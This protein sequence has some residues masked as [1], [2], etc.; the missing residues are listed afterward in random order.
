MAEESGQGLGN[1]ASA[2]M[3]TL[4]GAGVDH[5]FANPGT[6]EMHLVQA[7][8][9][10]TRIHPVLTLFEGVASGAADGFGRMAGR[11]AATLLHL[12]AGLGHATA[13]LH[14]ARR[15]GTPL[16]NL[17][18]DHAR[19]HRPFDA[20]LD[21]DI[22]GIARPFSSWVRTAR[23]AHGL[24]QDGAEA[25][26]AAS[27][28]HPGSLG[29]IATLAIPVDC[30][31]GAAPGPRAPVAIPARAQV[32]EAA[33]AAAASA[34]RSGTLLLLDGD[35]LTA[36]GQR[37]AAALAQKTGA[38]VSATT[39]PARVEQGPQLPALARLPYFPEDV[40]RALAGVH[41][42]LRVG[43]EAPVSFFAYEGVPSD[44][45]PEGAQVLTLAERHEDVLD[46]LA[47][48]GAAL[49]VTLADALAQGQRRPEV[50]TG[51]LGAR[52]VGATLAAMLP[53][54]AIVT[55]DSG[56]GGAAAVPCASAAPHS[57]LNLTGG[58]IGMG[59]P[60]ATGAA[61]AC[62]GRPVFALLGDGGALYSLQALWTQ[63]RESLPVITLIYNNR[64]YNILDHEYRRL[65]IN[66]VGPR[67]ESLFDLSRPD[68][69]FLALAK[70]FGVP[71]VR[72]SEGPALAEAIGRAL[73]AGGP[74][75]IEVML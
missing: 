24:A 69:D 43:A 32:P 66:E 29:S 26:A 38:A 4:A 6:S 19:H 7:L 27:T 59:G 50:P 35:A 23:S 8:E 67:A 28:A 10:E 63:A 40:Q 46:A 22:E 48:L 72:V 36:E 61:L 5:V 68:V 11:P 71:A 15:A 49:G 39:F 44:L 73:A 62:P 74:Q 34:L 57:W 65:G 18:G 33:I 55:V 25:V 51:A 64:R 20:P 47:R 54:D 37:W 42:I 45:T 2:L 9:G 41:T 58:S 3:S 12:G 31:W 16:I 53:E 70:G 75:L 13:N 30:A 14:N 56:G 1:G 21:A 52:Q 17:V 60:L